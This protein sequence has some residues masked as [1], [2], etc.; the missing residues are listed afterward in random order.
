MIGHEKYSDNDNLVKEKEKKVYFYLTVGILTIAI[1]TIFFLNDLKIVKYLIPDAFYKE[2]RVEVPVEKEIIKYVEKTGM[3]TSEFVTILNPKVD[4]II[5]EQIGMS[6]DKHA[7]NYQLPRKLVLGIINKES[8]FN[9]FAKSNVAIGLMQIYPKYH[10]DKI[11]DLKIKDKRKLFHID[12]NIEIGCKIFRE[13][14]DQTDGDLDET[15]HKYLSKNAT[16]EQKDKYKNN[17]LTTYAMLDFIEFQHKNTIIKEE[18]V[19]EEIKLLEKENTENEK[20]IHI[21]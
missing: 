20:R 12:I 13:Y 1:F 4:P 5:A 11:D 2:V 9:P 16:K 15:F 10:Q 3:K 14:F 8:A 21:D 18:D 17:V 7:K 19:E 6:V